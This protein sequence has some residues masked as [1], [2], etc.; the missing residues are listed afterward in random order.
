MLEPTG[1]IRDRGVL[2]TH[3]I[4]DAEIRSSVRAALQSLGPFDAK[5][6]YA[7]SYLPPAI[8][9]AQG[10]QSEFAAVIS[11]AIPCLPTHVVVGFVNIHLP[12]LN[13]LAQRLVVV[14]FNDSDHFVVLFLWLVEVE[15]CVRAGRME[16]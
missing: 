11:P 2:I 12:F 15:E 1:S 6:P 4:C 16:G 13:E 14:L 3:R 5:Q 10:Y 7:I 8:P 9:R